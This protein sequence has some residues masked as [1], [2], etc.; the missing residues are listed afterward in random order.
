MPMGS[1]HHISQKKQASQNSETVFQRHN[2]STVSEIICRE[3]G[4][5]HLGC[6]VWA[7]LETSVYHC[8]PVR[9]NTQVRE[10]IGGSIN[11][12]PPPFLPMIHWRPLCFLSLQLWDLQGQRLWFSKKAHLTR[13]LLNY[14]LQP[15]SKHF[16]LLV[17]RVSRGITILA[18]SRAVVTQGGGKNTCGTRQSTWSLLV[19]P[20]SL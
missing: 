14:S 8:V 9:N 20:G 12:S 6:S 11:F 4:Y 2:W 5:Y 13:D 15:I 7:K 1:I 16:G 10:P 3:S 18:G 17:S 19:L